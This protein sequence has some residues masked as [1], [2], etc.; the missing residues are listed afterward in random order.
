[1]KRIAAL[2]CA[3]AMMLGLCSCGDNPAVSDNSTA[4]ES[5]EEEKTGLTFSMEGIRPESME[6]I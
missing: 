4:A 1:M 6:N 5:S 3:G 2:V